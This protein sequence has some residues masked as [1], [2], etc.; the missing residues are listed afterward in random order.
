MTM[1]MVTV[2]AI[3]LI[4][5]LT[6]HEME[7]YEQNDAPHL[8]LTTMARLMHAMTVQAFPDDRATRA[9]LS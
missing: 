3:V 1:M 4:P 2:Y 8:M 6:K 7:M 9:V 5:V